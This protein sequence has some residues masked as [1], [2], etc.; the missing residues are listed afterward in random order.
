MSR[1]VAQEV[2]PSVFRIADRVSTLA[3]VPVEHLPTFVDHV[4][5]GIAGRLGLRG[6]RPLRKSKARP[7]PTIGRHNDRPLRTETAPKPVKAWAQILA[8]IDGPRY[9]P[10]PQDALSVELID[11][12]YDGL[13]FWYAAMVAANPLFVYTKRDAID[14][15]L[16]VASKLLARKGRVFDLNPTFALVKEQTDLATKFVTTSTTDYTE[17]DEVFKNNLVGLELRTEPSDSTQLKSAITRLKN[18][19]FFDGPFPDIEII[20]FANKTVRMNPDLDRFEPSKRSYARL[21]FDN[22]HHYQAVVP[23]TRSLE[24]TT[25][26]VLTAVRMNI[27]NDIAVVIKSEFSMVKENRLV[28][29]W[30]TAASTPND[31]ILH[32]FLVGTMRGTGTSDAQSIFDNVKEGTDGFLSCNT[33]LVPVHLTTSYKIGFDVVVAPFMAADEAARRCT[34]SFFT[35]IV[36]PSGI[37][38]VDLVLDS[39]V[40]DPESAFKAWALELTTN[41]AAIKA[42]IQANA[43]DAWIDL[44]FP[45]PRNKK[46]RFDQN[47]LK[48]VP[49]SYTNIIEILKKALNANP[50][51]FKREQLVLVQA[52][53]YFWRDAWSPFFVGAE[54]V[55][56]AENICFPPHSKRSLSIQNFGQSRPD[57]TIPLNEILGLRENKAMTITSAKEYLRLEGV[58]LYDAT[59][60][61]GSIPDKSTIVSFDEQ[62]KVTFCRKAPTTAVYTFNP[63]FKSDTTPSPALVAALGPTIF[64]NTKHSGLD[65]IPEQDRTIFSVMAVLVFMQFNDPQWV[66]LNAKHLDYY[67]K[68]I[69][70][71]L[72]IRK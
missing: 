33:T 46:H 72:L 10:A 30:F 16:I 39:L 52:C 19:G 25:K 40:E 42:A 22:G 51:L 9:D 56:H 68:K 26:D 29:D 65:A 32:A 61:V 41:E 64:P 67:R 57:H 59:T 58:Y 20:T 15:R 3:D 34:Q 1:I 14:L 24:L 36:I 6:Y 55:A 21:A 45:S 44:L 53:V 47:C 31:K 38:T 12:P 70:T 4:G 7:V 27:G 23:T 28:K 54:A 63:K 62:A 66:T 43:F 2:P 11:V 49:A 71:K 37:V 5:D 50:Y 17:L 48:E 69:A 60:D 35:Q 18:K 13:C 8:F